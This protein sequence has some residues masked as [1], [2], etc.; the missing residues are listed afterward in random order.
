MLFLSFFGIWSVL[1]YLDSL[2]SWSHTK[3]ASK[4]L[5]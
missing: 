4:L 3:E 2:Y 1:C 5:S